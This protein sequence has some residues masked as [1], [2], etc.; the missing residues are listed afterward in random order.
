MPS[1]I[2]R[3]LAAVMFTDI[4][5]FTERM[6]TDEN[7]ALNLL[8]EKITITKPLIKKYNGIYIKE[9]GDGTLSCF[10]SATEA[11]D[12][13][14][15]IQSILRNRVDLRIGLHLGEVILKDGDILG[16]SVNIASRI[17]KLSSSG[18]ICISSTIYN[19]LKNKKKYN[20]KHLGLHSFKGVGRLLDVYGIKTENAAINNKATEIERPVEN[21]LS[22]ISIIPLRNK[23]KKEDDFYAYS[24]SLDIFSKISSTSNIITSSMEDV[25]SLML[26]YKSKEISKK[27]Q[28]RYCLSGSL[29]KK[30][31]FF[32]LSLEL[33]D[34]NDKKIIWAD[35]W[36]EDWSNLASIES[37][38]SGNLIKILDNSS[39]QIQFL[40]S[41]KTADSEAYRIYLKGKYIYHNRQT[42]KD[43]LKAE[44]LFNES[45]NIDKNLI[46]PR[47]LLGEI[48]YQKGEYDD[49]LII[50]KDNLK[51][52]L[53]ANDSK[54]ISSSLSAMGAIH[55]QS[56]EYEKSLEYNLQ[57]LKIRE[58]INNIK[59]IA[60][61]YNALGAI[62]D[63]L[64]D[65]DKALNY[66]KDA[67]EIWEKT[68]DK[69]DMAPA[70]FNISNLYNTK[71]DLDNALK[72]VKDSIQLSKKVKNKALLGYS[73]NLLGAILSNKKRLDESLKYLKKA[74]KI[75]KELD[76][77]EG[78]ASALKSIGIIYYY[79][80]QYKQSMV[81]HKK[82]L[83]VRKAI[84]YKVGIAKSLRHIGDISKKTG[85]YDQSVESYNESLSI[86]QS[87]EDYDESSKIMNKLGNVYRKMGR[88]KDALSILLKAKDI[89]DEIK[90]YKN[91]GY[92]FLE[93]SSAYRWQGNY[94]MAKKY[95]L[96]SIK[97]AE[98]YDM[99]K[100]L[101][102]NFYHQS[103]MLISRNDYKSGKN[104]INK[105][106][107]IAKKIDSL[108]N[109]AKYMDCLGIILRHERKFEESILV[110][111]EALE[112]SESIGDRHGLRKYLN[113]IGLTKERN[114]D[115]EGAL[116]LYLKCL[117]I[118]K[119]I[120]E[121]R[122][123]AVS[124]NNIA[125]MY[126]ILGDLTN[127]LKNY[128]KAFSNA[129]RINYK[130]G[131]AG[132]AYNISGSLL[133]QNKYSESMKYIDISIEAFNEM[134]N[135][136]LKECYI[137]KI[138]LYVIKGNDL[139]IKE[140]YENIKNVDFDNNYGH[141]RNWELYKINSY[142]GNKDL[143][144]LN[145]AHSR[146]QEDLDSIGSIESKKLFIK[147]FTYGEEIIKA[148]NEVK[149]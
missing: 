111:N 31:N 105:A 53:D 44:A 5:G 16:D 54:N 12:C 3:K 101:A 59:G 140:Y 30:D 57:S 29:W 19:E 27:L 10:D 92:T 76:E 11:I 102:N 124:Y 123:I 42:N 93:I 52:S 48:L 75:K 127:S 17:E 91:L 14:T 49:A 18:G 79:K 72:S 46:P 74:L 141:I 106:I 26:E 71:G 146:L 35:S 32:N 137:Y 15:K 80:G 33:F 39:S 4:V 95:N 47:M 23:G 130:E 100:L 129:K 9:I 108:S 131:E 64:R 2:Q 132:F 67:I 145:N 110:V 149:K 78:I 37:T 84:G 135:P 20:L 66:Y 22:T 147:N 82:S 109:V 83:K 113:S 24:L 6:S 99:Q 58:K 119:K 96:E 134:D 40:N 98:K 142:I 144:F 90:D 104:V 55:F 56:A 60:K 45:V 62:H 69:S 81:Y 21:N 63:M 115:F 114:G 138:Y 34:H 1:N 41:D 103:L 128:K 25:E 36:L 13:A 136:Y 87:I 97:I 7:K 50:F 85:D 122:S 61:S 116:D 117:D 121:K 139:K 77:P 118:S 133:R 107:T 120:N 8:D 28:T 65:Y 94:D 125:G 68:N 143:R 51:M 86:M 112:I 148:F 126:Q 38:I 88:Y 70:V 43:I 89:K 73:Y